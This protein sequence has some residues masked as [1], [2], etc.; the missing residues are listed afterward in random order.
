[1]AQIINF[2]A[3]P[4]EAADEYLLRRM[5]PEEAKAYVKHVTEC[6][7]CSRVFA[8]NS[9]LFLTIRAAKREEVV[10]QRTGKTA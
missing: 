4:E 8:E 5:S 7:D 10:G 3:D 2:H 9:E 1:M 6:E